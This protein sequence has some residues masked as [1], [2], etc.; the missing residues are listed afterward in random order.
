MTA[1]L[2]IPL[3]KLDLGDNV[4][5][6]TDD[7]L[8]ESIRAHGVIQPVT[9]A[10]LPRGRYEVL[11]GHRRTLACMQLELGT[12]PAIVTERP[13]DLPLRQLAE[14]F[15]RREVDPIDTARTLRA[16]LDA[17]PGMTQGELADQVGKSIG[18]VNKKLALL[19]LDP[20]L[21]ARVSAGTL[22]EKTAQ[23][24]R[25][26]ST[27][28]RG[29]GRPRLLAPLESEPGRS[30]SVV[31]PLGA[32]GS[33]TLGIDRETG[34]VDLVVQQADQRGVF[35]LLQPKDAR[36]LALRLMQAFEAVRPVEATA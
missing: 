21:Q 33:A 16:W 27:R 17:H 36:L 10:R 1:V 14:N 24:K 5:E 26:A 34:T 6:V 29:P 31:I 22:S 23:A 7:G 12:V 19:E 32:A 20:E 30:R 2:Q 15:D 18:W 25:M 13:A 3:S 35:L 8:V 28:Q 11:Y 4:R 9:V